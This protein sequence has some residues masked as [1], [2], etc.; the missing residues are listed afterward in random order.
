[1]HHVR[2]L[3]LF[4]LRALHRSFCTMACIMAYINF[5]CMYGIGL[6]VVTQ[7][8]E[9]SLVSGWRPV[10]PVGGTGLTS[11]A[12]A[13]H[14]CSCRSF[15]LWSFVISAVKFVNHVIYVH[16][17]SYCVFELGLWKLLYSSLSPWYIFKSLS[18]LYHLR[19]SSRGTTG[20]VSIGSWVEKGS[21]N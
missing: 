12:E 13:A 11:W 1:M 7:V 9:W 8:W 6:R 5:N 4:H 17:V 15:F 2:Y 21:P 16:Y 14:S 18:C 20:V 3:F 19:P 10:W